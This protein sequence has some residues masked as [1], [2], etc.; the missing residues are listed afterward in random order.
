MGALAGPAGTVPVQEAAIPVH[1]IPGRLATPRVG[2][3]R[4]TSLLRKS[5]SDR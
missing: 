3:S 2:M 4:A 1:L 5:G